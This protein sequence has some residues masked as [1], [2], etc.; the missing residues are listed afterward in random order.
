MKIKRNGEAVI[1]GK[2]IGKVQAINLTRSGS[3]RRYEL[4]ARGW[5]AGSR[6]SHD[7]ITLTGRT[8]Q[9]LIDRVTEAYREAMK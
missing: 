3:R 4:Y 6:F 7:G 2:V 1:D 8:Q 5:T 9:D